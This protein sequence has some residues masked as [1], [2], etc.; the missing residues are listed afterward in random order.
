MKILIEKFIT[1]LIYA[2]KLPAYMNKVTDTLEELDGKKHKLSS[3]SFRSSFFL[4]MNGVW[5]A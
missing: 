1:S 4:K 5:N 2:G 3:S